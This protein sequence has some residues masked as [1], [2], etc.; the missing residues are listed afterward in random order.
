M[1]HKKLILTVEVKNVLP[2]CTE[3]KN[4]ASFFFVFTNSAN[5]TQTDKL[6]SV[7]PE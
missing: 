7:E 6:I 5:F 1:F 4:L 3:R 2:P